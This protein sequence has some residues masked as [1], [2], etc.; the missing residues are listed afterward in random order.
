MIKRWLENRRSDRNAKFLRS[1]YEYAAG[2]LLLDGNPDSVMRIADDAG[3]LDE[4]NRGM[5][6]A[7]LDYER[8]VRNKGKHEPR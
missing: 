7:V 2:L 3:F 4:F 1:G 5:R 6:M 8:L